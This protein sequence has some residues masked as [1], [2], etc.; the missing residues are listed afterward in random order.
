MD[1]QTS[2]ESTTTTTSTII[3][4]M[5][6]ESLLAEKKSE[7]NDI[8]ATVIGLITLGCVIGA[9]LIAMGATFLIYK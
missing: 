1:P 8:S 5:V 9:V 4:N 7:N 6:T 3:I 2:I